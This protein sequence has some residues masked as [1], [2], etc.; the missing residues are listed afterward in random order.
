MD[1]DVNA[2]GAIRQGLQAAENAGDADAVAALMTDDAVLMVP[3][4]PVQE[5]KTGCAGFMHD[6]MSWIATK[7][8]RHITYV[9]AE[10]AIIGDIAFDRG[11]F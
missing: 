9:S 8:D 7:F 2:I 4:F 3:D 1:S 6:V 10:I 5:G 11:A